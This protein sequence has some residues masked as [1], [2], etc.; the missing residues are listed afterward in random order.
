M[1][2]ILLLLFIGSL[3]LFLAAMPGNHTEAED[4]FEYSRLIEEGHGAELFHPHHLLYLPVQKAV[5]QSARL[6]GYGGRSYYVA[7]AV[8][9][10][11]GSVAL[12]LFFLI[13]CRLSDG[14]RMIPMVGTLGLLFSYGFL[15]YA[16]EVEIY[17]PAMALILAAIYSALR[18]EGSRAW[19]VAGIALAAMAVL[20]HTINAA[21]ALVVIP[22]IYLLVPKDWKRAMLHAVATLAVVGLVYLVVQNTCGTFHPP[23]DT[24]SEG[25]LRPGTIGKAMAGSG[26]CLLSANFLFA[27]G[28]VAE[29][30]QTM[31][32][33][34]VFAEELFAAAHLPV[35]LK[36]VA[37][38]TFVLALAGMV[39]AATTVLRPRLFNRSLVWPLLWLGGAILPTLMLEPSNPELWVLALAP[40]WAVFLWLASSRPASLRHTAGLAVV[41]GLLGVHNIAAGMGS[42]KN[43]DGDYN[44]KKAAWVLEHATA[45]DVV[46]T[47]D[48][49]V[50]SF[51]LDYWSKAEI[52]NLNSQ[53]WKLGQTT[54]VFDDVFHPPAAVGCRYPAFAK[55]IA[56][57]ASVLQPRCR[58]IHNDQFGGVWVV[59]TE[60]SD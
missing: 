22:S 14:Q 38:L 9:M 54:Y 43:S 40:L 37:P 25:W 6:L 2:R 41:V 26:Q 36:T 16:C 30:L 11:S 23:V 59:D 3:L 15:R 46:Q 56:M 48:S 29:K 28:W 21:A 5:F 53:D 52:R 4:A 58:K 10:F 44:V 17:V 7:R 1:A 8:S 49:F 57:T 35:W 42:V 24:A 45:Q 32:P 55:K 39:G 33:Y 27:Y 51:Y 31:F 60:G 34:R 50:F 13:G 12:C 20:M 18:A 19:F 47:A